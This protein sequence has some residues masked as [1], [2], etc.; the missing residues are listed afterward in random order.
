MNVVLPAILID[1]VQFDP[2]RTAKRGES[3][4]FSATT[5]LRT[6]VSHLF[7]AIRL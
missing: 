3:I 4:S 7:A 2:V 5:N 6:G 1:A